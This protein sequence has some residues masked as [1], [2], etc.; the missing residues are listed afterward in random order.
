MVGL[1][2]ARAG[3]APARERAARFRLHHQRPGAQ[4]VGET[5]ALLG[6]EQRV[7]P[8]QRVDDLALEPLRALDAKPGRLDRRL[9]TEGLALRGIRQQRERPAVV[10][11]RLGPFGLELVE[12]RGELRDLRFVEPEL[13]GQE[14]ERTAHAESSREALAGV[15]MV[16][17]AVEIAFRGGAA[18]AAQAGRMMGMGTHDE[19]PLAGAIA[20]GGSK[21]RAPCLAPSEAY[22]CR[23]RGRARGPVGY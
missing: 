12:D 3:G 19:P 22:Q 5:R 13:P 15:V 21:A 7:D 11:R 16:L 4:Q 14:P 18:A 1:E 10:H 8:A 2:T 6:P 9:V 20:P 23:Q 17:E